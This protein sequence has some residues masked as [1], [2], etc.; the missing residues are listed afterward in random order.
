M[1]SVC[2]RALEPRILERLLADA[3]AGAQVI[4]EGRVRNCNGGREVC[5]LEY[6][7]HP[8]L[9]AAEGNRII[10]AARSRYAILH[11]A[12]AHRTGMLEVGECAVWV[13]VSA[14]HRDAA[15]SACRFIIDE[16]KS[17]LPIWK[18]E[19]YADGYSDWVGC[20]HP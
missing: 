9:A 3:G 13:G 6:E 17:R 7:A 14:P 5:R 16:L 18:K 15:F 2:D 12:A 10:E 11:A 19:H 8:A 20:E 4:F 1:F